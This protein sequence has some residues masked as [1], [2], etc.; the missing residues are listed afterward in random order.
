VPKFWAYLNEKGM[1]CVDIKKIFNIAVNSDVV[2]DM[3]SAIGQADTASSMLTLLP[4]KE[5]MIKHK[6]SEIVLRDYC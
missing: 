2:D 4:W 6:V 5:N 1:S 3:L